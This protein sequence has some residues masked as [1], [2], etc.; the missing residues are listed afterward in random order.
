MP[1]DVLDRFTGS[2]AAE[3]TAGAVG[4]AEE[5]LALGEPGLR[6]L[7]DTLI[8][9]AQLAVGERWERGEWTVAQEHR[10]TDTMSA[11]L[12]RAAETVRRAGPRGSVIVTC[13]E[14]EWH[15]LTT[16]VLGIA[17]DLDGWEPVRVSPSLTASQL[18]AAIYDY[19]PDAVALSCSMPG[20]LVGAHRMVMTSHE[21]G[22]PVVV[23][24]QAFG[25]DGHRARH[26]AADGWAPSA[27]HIGRALDG[28]TRASVEL[29]GR[30]PAHDEY[31]HVLRMERSI[32]DDLGSRWPASEHGSADFSAVSVMAVRA[33][34]A[35]LLCDEL[36]IL[37]DQFRWQERRATLGAAAPAGAIA[38]ALLTALPDDAVTAREFV[39]LAALE[40]GSDVV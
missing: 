25:T 36:G 14:G 15:S 9:Q 17:L 29:A 6:M 22:T 20:N 23:G 40:A 39:R 10:A 13:A 37:A 27:S 35:S 7:L 1:A 19:G 3:D 38:R 26:V 28:L 12:D 2:V 18:L 31:G 34:L 24:G 5:V 8:P 11:I 16:R 32:V 4:I 21:T 33:L 30:P